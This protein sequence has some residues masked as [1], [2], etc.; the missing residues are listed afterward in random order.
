MTAFDIELAIAQHYSWRVNLI[1]P[2]VSWGLFLHECDLLVCTKANYL[3]EIEIKV[4]KYDLRKDREK[5]HQ[6]LSK[7]IKRFYFGI[8]DTLLSEIEYIPERAG[9]LTVDK[10]KRVKKYRESA[11]NPT[12]QPI[13][14]DMREKLMHLGCMRIWG[15]M[16]ALESYKQKNKTPEF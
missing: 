1:V 3:T 16:K 4:D 15:L 8:P 2:N 12:A 14:A 9:I 11:I 5:R 6:H 7:K 13:G 10:Y